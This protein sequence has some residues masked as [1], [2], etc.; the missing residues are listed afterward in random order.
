MLL[1]SHCYC[2]CCC[3]CCCCCCSKTM[4]VFIE[5]L[6]GWRVSFQIIILAN[7]CFGGLKSWLNGL[8]NFRIFLVFQFGGI[9]SG[10]RQVLS[11]SKTSK[12]CF[13]RLLLYL[14]AWLER[15]LNTFIVLKSS[16]GCCCCSNCSRYWCWCCCSRCCCFCCCCSLLMLLHN[17]WVF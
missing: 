16:C 11:H 4:L 10:N 6:G 7:G 3:C 1:L 15:F 9:H 14:Q 2:Y 8:S 17:A 12:T 13:K 5:I